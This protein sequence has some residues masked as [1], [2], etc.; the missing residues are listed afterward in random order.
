M[1]SK[2]RF[3]LEIKALL[4][5][6]LIFFAPQM[7]FASTFVGNGGTTTDVDLLITI[8]QIQETLQKLDEKSECSCPEELAQDPLCEPLLQLND[9]EQEFC[10]EMLWNQRSHLSSLL[11]PQSSLQF[12]WAETAITINTEG[13]HKVVDAVTDAAKQQIT[14]HRPRF[15]DLKQKERIFLL[16]HEL[17]H[18][19]KIG[20]DAITDTGSYGPF[21]NAGGGRKLLNSLGAT[22]AMKAVELKQLGH[23]SDTFNLSR[24]NKRRW[25]GL[26]L[27]ST[28]VSSGDRTY[29]LNTTGGWGAL[30]EFRY[31]WSWIGSYVAARSITFSKKLEESLEVK[32][33]IPGVELG[34]SFCYSPFKDPL[35]FWGQSHL[36]VKVGLHLSAYTYEA[37]D[38]S[39]SITDEDKESL[40]KPQLALGFDYYFPLNFGMWLT[41]GSE[42]FSA[43]YEYRSLNLSYNKNLWTTHLGV[44]YGF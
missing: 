7:V 36:L 39:V 4:I 34:A 9:H 42:L 41:L 21:K 38:P 18:L 33:T 1:K 37:S 29:L 32:E 10:K 19:V 44:H 11:D 24:S 20:E 31:Q 3:G 40:H 14:I 35:T 15:L 23:Y 5:P 22:V 27:G 8:K 12:F 30:F 2:F 25:V 17:F 28:A 43:N 6:L 26:K 13:D 16:T